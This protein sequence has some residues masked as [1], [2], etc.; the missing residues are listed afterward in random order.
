MSCLML[1]NPMQVPSGTL[2][3]SSVLHSNK[4]IAHEKSVLHPRHL[5][6]IPAHVIFFLH[7]T[8]KTDLQYGAAS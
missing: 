2:R 3:N 8:V 5:T 4:I 7:V 6:L 1:K